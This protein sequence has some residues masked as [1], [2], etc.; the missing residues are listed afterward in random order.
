MMGA[1]N[2]GPF[3]AMSPLRADSCVRCKGANLG[4]V[5]TVVKGFDVV[6]GMVTSLFLPMMPPL[7]TGGKRSEETKWGR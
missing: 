1:G 5:S 6:P 2:E 4:I 7:W 3:Q